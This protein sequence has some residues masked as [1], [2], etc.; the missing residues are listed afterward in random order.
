MNRIDH[1]T[2]VRSGL[3]EFTFKDGHNE[4]AEYRTKNRQ[5]KWTDERRKAMSERLKQL[6]EA[7]RNDSNS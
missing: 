7:K 1:I 3:M 2:M 5:P 4:L 6:K